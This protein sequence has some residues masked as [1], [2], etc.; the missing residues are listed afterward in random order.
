MHFIEIPTEQTTAI[1]D[2][3]LAMAATLF[4]VLI[5]A[6]GIKTDSKKTLIWIAAFGFLALAAALGAIA[7]GIEM[8]KEL[9]TL[10]WHPINLCLG[11]TV[12]FFTAGVI[13]DINRFNIAGYILVLLIIS[14]LLFFIVTLIIPD[15]FLIFI[16]YEAL[17]MLFALVSYLILSFGGKL[18][19]AWLMTFGILISLLAS[20]IQAMGTFQLTLIWEFNYNGLFHILQIPGLLFIY[21]GIIRE[22]N[23][24]KFIL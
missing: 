24:R 21:A 5:R 8:T 20:V 7:H 3:L 2:V 16:L 11:L 13:Y 18:R 4:I 19:G 6:K 22:I 12:A 14:S 15:S 10:V 9:N 17:A 1:T 23:S